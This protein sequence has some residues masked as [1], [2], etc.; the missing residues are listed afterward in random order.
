MFSSK[1]KIFFA[2]CFASIVVFTNSIRAASIDQTYSETRGKIVKMS[3]AALPQTGLFVNAV[4]DENNYLRI[5]VWHVDSNGKAEVRLSQRDG[6]TI[7]DV[8][9]YA[10]NDN[11]HRLVVAIRDSTNK[12]K[13]IGYSLSLD[14]RILRRIGEK[15][16]SFEITTVK[17]TRGNEASSSPHKAVFIAAR[18]SNGNLFTG[19]WQFRVDGSFR[20]KSKAERGKVGNI[21][22]TKLNAQN[23]AV[24]AQGSESEYVLGWYSSANRINRAGGGR[25]R[26]LATAGYELGFPGGEIVTFTN[27]G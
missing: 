27:D 26:Q 9:V 16:T 23:P 19:L 13:L 10:I 12:L 20:R 7:K 1:P 11:P 18:L 5:I 4:R 15:A 21:A 24:L 17:I 3:M 22:L 2:I 8:G 6:G 25:V 14:G